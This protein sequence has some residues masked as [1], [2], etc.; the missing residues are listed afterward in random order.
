MMLSTTKP[1]EPYTTPCRADAC[2]YHLDHSSELGHVALLGLAE[3]AESQYI[4][5]TVVICA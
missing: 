2:I 3:L 4:Q 1:H 5:S